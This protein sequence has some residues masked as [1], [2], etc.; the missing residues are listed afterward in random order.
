MYVPLPSGPTS[1][2]SAS[3]FSGFSSQVA[4]SSSDCVAE[5]FPSTIAC[6][7]P[8]S[9]TL[10]SSHAADPVLRPTTISAADGAGLLPVPVLHPMPEIRVRSPIEKLPR[11]AIS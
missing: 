5:R 2:A 8:L 6:R 11:Q 3:A 7:S 1:L 10:P 9:A 4:A